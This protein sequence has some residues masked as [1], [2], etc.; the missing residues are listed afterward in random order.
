MTNYT[1]EL[2]KYHVEATRI[3]KWVFDFSAAS[4]DDARSEATRRMAEAY[5]SASHIEMTVERQRDDA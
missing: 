4:P 2:D 3:D 1:P 5:P